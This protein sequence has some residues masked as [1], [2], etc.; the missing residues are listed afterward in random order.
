MHWFIYII[1]II[2]L[3]IT[4][5]VI[6]MPFPIFMGIVFVLFLGLTVANIQYSHKVQRE[7]KTIELLEKI[8]EQK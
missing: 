6:D 5:H 1:S 7:E 3:I 2:V 8:A 4:D